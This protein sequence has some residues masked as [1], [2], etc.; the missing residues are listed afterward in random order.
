[1]EE[2]RQAWGDM[3]G[4]RGSSATETSPGGQERAS[5]GLGGWPAAE[6]PV[7]RRSTSASPP[8]CPPQPVPPVAGPAGT[9]AVRGVAGRGSWA[10]AT[11]SL[12]QST[13][14]QLVGH[15]LCPGS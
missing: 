9:Q 11:E 5:E 15:P 12:G 7:T 2:V 14:N 6:T 3:V 13:A 4:T 8:R 1:M 10:L